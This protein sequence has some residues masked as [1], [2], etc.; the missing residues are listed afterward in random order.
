MKKLSHIQ[1]F[2]GNQ[3]PT[4]RP[5]AF[6]KHLVLLSCFALFATCLL[7]CGTVQVYKE[8]A[9]PVFHSGEEALQI[10]GK[11]D[12]LRV[13]TFNIR[14]AIKTTLAASELQ[15]F[16]K[17]KNADVYLLQEMDEKGVKEIAKILGLNYLYFPVVYKTSAKKDIGNAIL[18]RGA[19]TCA[20]KLLLPHPKPLSKSRREVTIAE[21]TVHGEKILVYS[22][23]TETVVMS[24]KNRMDQVDAI[25]DHAKAQLPAYKY[26]LIGG[27]FNTLFTKSS[28]MAVKKFESNGFDWSTA[29]VGT[30][31]RAFLGLIKP[32][33]D[34]IF[35]KGLKL[36]EAGKIEASK[37]S[38]HFPVLATFSMKP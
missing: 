38:D 32:R 31:A 35:S 20:E 17:T 37:S 36:M 15:Q 9:L 19:I 7:S 27:D 5:P 13:V 28:K 11:A 18:T 1:P 8:P 26:V 2:A 25:I 6:R 34:Y 14:K 24:R 3:P 23:Q 22:V 10:T 30:T 29:S 33:H 21:V 4:Q 12:S 16:P